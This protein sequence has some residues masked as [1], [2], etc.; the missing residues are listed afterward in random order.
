MSSAH[1]L[2]S[3]TG[4]YCLSD[5]G[6]SLLMGNI[7]LEC[8]P[9]LR[10]DGVFDGHLVSAHAAWLPGAQSEAGRWIVHSLQPL[11]RIIA[12]KSTS[13][14]TD[15]FSRAFLDFRVVGESSAAPSQPAI[16]PESAITNN[17]DEVVN[18]APTGS[19][20][21]WENDP[22]DS[23]SVNEPSSPAVS[24]APPQSEV[25]V[26][27]EKKVPAVAAETA[28]RRP[29]GFSLSGRSK[30]QPASAPNS[31][32]KQQSNAVASTLIAAPGLMPQS[33]VPVAQ[34]AKT[35]TRPFESLRNRPSA[36]KPDEPRAPY[37]YKPVVQQPRAAIPSSAAQLSQPVVPA[38]AAPATA[39]VKRHGAF[40]VSPARTSPAAASSSQPRQT[41]S[42]P[43]RG[44]FSVA[45]EDDTPA[46][47]QAPQRTRG[48]LANKSEDEV[49]RMFRISP[50]PTQDLDEDIP[51]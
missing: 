26:E 29:S 34:T 23:G 48:T 20:L 24:Y 45:P 19:P 39:A 13:A 36:K 25:P 22:R 47:L 16:S 1:T 15:E 28:A 51:Y 50:R 4:P 43:R 49:A 9:A 32:Q 46:H 37:V 2:A 35:S 10:G 14:L 8:A 17:T 6:R 40:G 21:P 41:S 33:G 3:F 42:A 11:S 30:S 38:A 18:S 5:D 31:A 44:G 27:S 7:V 12:Q